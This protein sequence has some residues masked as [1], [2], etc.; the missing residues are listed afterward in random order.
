MNMHL[1][2]SRLL[3]C[4]SSIH[5]RNLSTSAQF[6]SNSNNDC[7]FVTTPIFYVND[8]PHIGH[9]YSAT[10]AD[11][12]ARFRKIQS[13]VD[14]LFSTGTDE[15]GLKIQKVASK[16]NLTPR[17]LC[18]SN[19]LKFKSLFDD[20]DIRYDKFIRTSDR[21]HIRAV[22]HVFN[23]LVDSGL[24]Y[25]SVYSGW[26]CI[27]DESFLTEKQ[28]VE[29]KLPSGE[30]IKVS[31]ESG[32]VVEWN[33][34]TN[35]KFKLSHFQ[36]DL[37][38]W[39]KSETVI[40]PP[41]YQK[42][43]ERLILEG[44]PDLS[45]SRPI[46]RVHWGIP[47]ANDPEQTV[48]VWVDALVNYLT[49]AGYPDRLSVW[50]PDLQIIGKDILKF[51]ALYWPAILMAL[52]LEP[53]R[54]LLVHSHWTVDEVKMSKSLGNVVDPHS[55]QKV[56]TKEGVRYCLLRQGTPFADNS[57]RQS[58][59]IDLLN[60]ELADTVGNLL[61]RCTGKNLN[62]SQTFPSLQPEFLQSS[63]LGRN[64]YDSLLTLDEEV[65]AS[66][67]EYNFC[68][69]IQDIMATLR[70]ANTFFQEET[71]WKWKANPQHVGSIIHMALAAVHAGAIMLQPI[72][73]KFASNVL[74]VLNVSQEKRLWKDVLNFP[75]LNH[76]PS[77]LGPKVV[78]FK[79]IIK[80]S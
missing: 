35:Y 26:Y 69:G 38:H 7:L 80:A 47:L 29:K 71:P 58:E 54:H 3:R 57:W 4:C 25:G 42:D 49:A 44:L 66:Y 13:N 78:P 61:L 76:K 50:P 14:V 67:N 62:P 39:L 9:L 55:A 18:N 53:P 16:H 32:H 19:S 73:P 75:S 51:H 1:L 23:D 17:D 5:H 21:S 27:S 8:A 33:H 64:L 34:E 52:G 48:Y 63:K 36:D 60:A 15:H 68:Q 74:N 30:T 79:K 56:L 24:V 77:P 6:P 45:I 12:A 59:S 20:F 65:M 28:V 46:N 2:K 22:Q 10:L 70:L 41:R 40:T 11:A 72:V 31:A 43:L 37:M